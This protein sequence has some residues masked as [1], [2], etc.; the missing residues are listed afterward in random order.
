MDAERSRAPD[1][2]PARPARLRADR[3]RNHSPAARPAEVNYP[4]PP[5]P[6]RHP[7]Q[8]PPA[9]DRSERR[10]P[11]PHRTR[12]TRR[13]GSTSTPPD[14]PGPAHP[15]TPGRPTCGRAR[16]NRPGLAP[17]KLR[18]APL[19][20]THHAGRS[21]PAGR[22]IPTRLP[23]RGRFGAGNV[24]AGDTVITMRGS[25]RRTVYPVLTASLRCSRLPPHGDPPSTNPR[26]PAKSAVS[27]LQDAQE[28][29][30]QSVTFVRRLRGDAEPCSTRR[31]SAACDTAP[32][33]RH[34]PGTC[35]SV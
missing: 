20:S 25:T 5:A 34:I 4:G 32:V 17:T 22:T 21:D 8:D 16:S 13:N 24:S 7:E 10:H 11:A 27:D 2:R 35:G 1:P 26:T 18:P 23:L 14:T 31:A 29:P 30:P 6:A 9:I 28:G 3:N 15:Q 12:P 19:S 33:P